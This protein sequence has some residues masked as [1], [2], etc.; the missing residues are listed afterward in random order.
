[1]K[2]ASFS[3]RTLRRFAL[4]LLPALA[5]AA[6]CGGEKELK[7]HPVTGKVSFQGKPAAGANVVLH[8]KSES[9]PK[10]VVPSATVKDDG[11]FQITTY[12]SGDGA[13]PGDYTATIEWHKMIT[14][15]GGSGR[16]PNVL[17][18]QYADAKSSPVSVTVKEGS[19]DIP[20]IEIK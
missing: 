5:L 15:E 2:S 1:M 20:P 16:G 13:P 19:N 8:P 12:Q 11:T 18:P 10:N 4:A 17:P 7:V 3:N 14:D 9:I 6:G